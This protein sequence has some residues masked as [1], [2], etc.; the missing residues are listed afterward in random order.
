[1]LRGKRVAFLARHGV[2]HRI[3]PSSSTRANIYGMSAWRRAH[4][5][6]ERRR[7]PE[8]EYKPPDIVGPDQFFNRTK[9]RIVPSP[10]WL[11]RAH[12]AFAHPLA[13]TCRRSRPTRRR[14]G[15]TVHRGGTREHGRAAASTLAESSCTV[16]G[17]MSSA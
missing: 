8:D 13:T 1:M 2:E 17:W 12:V 14:V 3:L 7:Q 15:A 9:G 16:G 10:A 4:P 5:V 6:G 11:C